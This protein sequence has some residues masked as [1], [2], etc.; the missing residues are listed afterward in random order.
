MS[1]AT[2]KSSSP[3]ATPAAEPPPFLRPSGPC[4]HDA[5]PPGTRLGELE[6]LGILGVGGFG[7]VYLAQDHALD[8]RVAVKEYLPAQ[9]ALRGD[10]GRIGV[11]APRFAAAFAG[12]LRAFVNEAR[13]LAGFD[14]P[15]M[16]KV[17]RYWES[18]GTGYMVMPHVEG[19]TLR[20]ARRAGTLPLHEAALRALLLPL[21]DA[22]AMLHGRGVFHRDVAP[23]N[24]LIQ[25]D[26]SPMLLDFGSARRVIGGSSEALTAVLKPRYAP[27]EQYGENSHVRQGPW[28]DLYA[29]GG[30]MA[31]LLDGR[32]PPAATARALHDDMLPLAERHYPGVSRNFLATID[33]ALA[34]RPQDRPQSVAEFRAAIRGDRRPPRPQAGQP[35]AAWRTP[36][37]AWGVGAG[38]AALTFVAATWMATPA[39]P[40]GVAMP[41]QAAAPAEALP[42]AAIGGT[43]TI[44]RMTRTTANGL[45]LGPTPAARWLPHEEPAPVEVATAEAP[46][47]QPLP[48][49]AAAPRSQA[50]RGAV[51]ATARLARART[52]PID[53]PPPSCSQANAVLRMLCRNQQ[54][55]DPRHVRHA[56]CAYMRDDAVM[57]VGR[58]Q[59]AGR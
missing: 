42:L 40:A 14:H 22:L 35:P 43:G 51:P 18:N 45:V 29:L 32:P 52:L 9:L 3:S 30:V 27:I 33:W 34:V 17:H 44:V 46:T 54:C 31:Y 48:A 49:A 57:L 47:A 12:G 20:Q 10:D 4:G 15:A 58:E 16:V 50:A 7:I 19:T 59:I 11:R 13:L 36:S 2:G 37:F 55:S 25:P 28:T 39:P 8:R 53:D 24:I 23:D 38:A 21:L 26:G 6:L 1:Q 41:V 56:Q 5:L